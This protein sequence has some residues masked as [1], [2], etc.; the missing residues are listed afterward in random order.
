MK[1][2]K[3]KPL[4]SIVMPVYNASAYIKEALDSV[5]SQSYKNIEVI[6]V[7]DGS[8]DNG[9]KILKEYALKE[10]RLK[11][12]NCRLNK[13]PAK[14][15]NLG[16]SNTKGDFIARMDADDLIPR[17]RIVKQVKYLLDHPDVVVVGGQVKLVTK[18][19]KPIIVK[20]FPRKHKDI[21]KFGFV[22]MPIQQGAMM[23]NR[24][25]L[26][27]KFVWY[28]EELKTSED[29]DFLFRVFKFG[30]GANLGSIVLF[31]R[32]H[33]VSISRVEHPKKILRQAFAVRRQA[34]KR[35]TE[36][37]VWEKIKIGIQIYLQ[38]ILILIIPS[39]LIYPLYYL[40]RGML[41]LRIHKKNLKLSFRYVKNFII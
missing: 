1:M 39:F 40:W 22:T 3:V 27:K 19:L 33:G 11:V 7:N 24:S 31:Y 29:L 38:L 5:F 20:K 8:K 17:N 4:V 41:Y 6:A 9:L 37:S 34:L 12:I 26:P 32:Q 10:K 35:M 18:G 13:G 2:N 15:S 14:A 36:L 25:L 16:I 23:V 28:K 30:K 21:V